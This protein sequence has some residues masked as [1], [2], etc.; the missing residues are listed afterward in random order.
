MRRALFLAFALSAASA[1]ADSEF[2]QGADSVRITAKPCADDKVLRLIPPAEHADYRAARAEV[3]GTSYSGCWRPIFEK[4][5]VYLR[6]EDGDQGLIPFR[7]L[8]PLKDA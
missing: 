2:R 8:K 1:F 3:A 7:D 6:Y 5:A 4:E